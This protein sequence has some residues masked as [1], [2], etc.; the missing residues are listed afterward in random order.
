MPIQDPEKQRIAQQ[1]LLYVKICR[2]CG[3]RN[4]IKAE[5]CRR[6]RSKNLRPK[7]REL[8]R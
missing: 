3:A 7:R 1:H 5:K 2:R 8:R 4:S 6:C